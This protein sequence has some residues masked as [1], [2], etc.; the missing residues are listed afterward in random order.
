VGRVSVSGV[1][2]VPSSMVFQT[3]PPSVETQQVEGMVGCGA[4]EVMRPDAFALPD[5]YSPSMKDGPLN[6]HAK[7]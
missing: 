6:S 7:G 2:L 1:Q 5:Q 4:I 3:P